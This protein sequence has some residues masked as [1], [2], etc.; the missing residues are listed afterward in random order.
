MS[1]KNIDTKLS[2]ANVEK[3]PF[4]DKTFDTVINTMAFT[5]YPNGDK[6]M[7]ELKRVLKKGGK[8]LLV[9]FY[10]I[11]GYK[12]IFIHLKCNIW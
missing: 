3:L 4:Q 2:I 10:E 7:A 9:D 8:L 6:A 1:S 5:G 11:H 12:M